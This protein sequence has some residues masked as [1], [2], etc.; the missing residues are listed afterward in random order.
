M[1]N[2]IVTEEA[3]GE[4]TNKSNSFVKNCLTWKPN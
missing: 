2:L 3:N 4:I 1:R